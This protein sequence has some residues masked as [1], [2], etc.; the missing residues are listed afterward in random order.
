MLSARTL[1]IRQR[2]R[3]E[4]TVRDGI[5]A[6]ICQDTHLGGLGD[7]LANAEVCHDALV[8]LAGEEAF[9]AP[10]DLTFGPAVRC[11]SCDVVDSR[12]VEPHADDDGAIEGGVGLSG[13]CAVGCWWCHVSPCKKGAYPTF[14][15]QQRSQALFGL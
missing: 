5:D 11:A 10:D 9:E 15:T 6:S 14:G 13:A 8:D 12:L 1:F 2:S 3:A 7:V 4:T